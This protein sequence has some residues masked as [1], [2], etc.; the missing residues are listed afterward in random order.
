MKKYIIPIII[1]AATAMLSSCDALDKKPIST[2]APENYF[3]NETDLQ[4]FTNPLYNNMLPKDAFENQSDHYVNYTLSNELRGGSYRTVPGSGGGWTWTDLRRINTLLGN[5]GNCDDEQA[6]AKYGALARFF[7]AYFYAD[8]VRRFGDVPWIDHE[9]GSAE[10]QLYA[11]RDNREVVLTHMIEDVDDAI[12]NLPSAV[13]VYR[14][15]KWA[16]LALKSQFCL[17]EGTF[18][19]YHTELEFEGH[20]ADY[21][22]DLAAKAAKEIIDGGKYRLA[23]DYTTLFS[24]VDADKG[25]Y[26]LAINFDY[27]LQFFNNTSAFALLQTQGRPGLT[28]KFVDSFLMKDGSRF[29]DKTGWNEMTFNDEV[30]DRDPRLA[31]CTRTPGY[32]RFGQTAVLAPDLNSSC[33][34]FQIA[35]WVMNPTADGTSNGVDRVDRSFNDL[36]V[37]RYAEVL[38]N[39]AEALAELGTLT[40]A[41]LDLSVNLLRKRVGMP[42]MN[43][44]NANANPD[45]YLSSEE[46]GYRNVN[47]G[48]KGV[49]LE[50]RRER[51]VELAQEGFR[52]YDLIRWKE[53]LCINQAMYGHYFPALGEYDLDGDGKAETCLYQGSTDSKCTYKYEVGTASGVKLTEGTKGYLDPHQGVEHKFDESRDY[54]YPIPSGERQLNN[55]LAQNPGWDDGLSF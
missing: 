40:Q 23:A 31:A 30:K 44:A 26:M 39:Y 10:D 32:H 35:K 4:L 38:L 18:R 50:I 6:V 3:R 7:R 33:T 12:A 51:A 27:S 55:N 52:Y 25:E 53:G 8:K 46:Y 20:D 47:G 9:L 48:N 1:L 45:W 16:A 29:T 43:L 17:F 42:S 37:Y 13:S 2:L 28:K 21:Y 15:N 22:L 41:D 54:F 49:I 19:K 36:P 24:E 14:V 11:P 34:G 5:L